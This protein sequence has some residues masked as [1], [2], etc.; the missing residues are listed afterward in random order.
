MLISYSELTS[1][2]P[3]FKSVISC[4]ML[5]FCP[6]PLLS[7]R[8]YKTDPPPHLIL[9]SQSLPSC[10]LQHFLDA[11]GVKFQGPPTFL[12]ADTALSRSR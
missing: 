12:G 1:A 3:K 7:Y 11:W 4:Q 9:P 5:Q 2:H 6:S 8:I 10:M